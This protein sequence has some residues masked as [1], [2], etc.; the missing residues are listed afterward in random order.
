MASLHASRAA[1]LSADD[2]LR[3][4]EVGKAQHPL[5]RALTVLA[6]IEPSATRG[7]LARLPTGRRD[8]RLLSV[9][10]RTFGRDLAGL[11]R[12]PEC[13]EA[14]EFSVAV[15]DLLAA[16]GEA[17][18]ADPL[19]AASADY[20]V[21]YRLPD[22]SDVAEIIRL[23]DVAEA[24]QRLLERCIVQATYEGAGVCLDRLPEAVV[25][26]V[27]EQMAAQDPLAVIELALA[28]PACGCQWQVILDI[29]SFLWVKIEEQARRLLREVDM[30]ARAY[31]WRE[32]D[33][34]AMGAARRQAYLEMVI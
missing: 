20:A 27:V 7:E 22:S 4:W 34:L 32:A 11:G 26:L 19:T 30:L 28:C 31:G 1:G 13:D 14:V 33:I 2:L 23:S 17:G 29:A 18:C 12:C 5:D 25:D 21:T 15:L 8:A 9:Y 6:A 3:V 24:R 16:S 10:E